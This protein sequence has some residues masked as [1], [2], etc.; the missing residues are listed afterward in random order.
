MEDKKSFSRV[1]FGLIIIFIA[2]LIF[3]TLVLRS[4]PF[5]VFDSS[6]II[7]SNF[8]GMYGIGLPIF[9]YLFK[10]REKLDVPRKEKISFK[11]GF[12]LF[13]I[14]FAVMYVVNLGCTVI[15]TLLGA[16]ITN[17]LGETIMGLNIVSAFLLIVIIGPILE[18]LLF[19]KTLYRFSDTL[20]EN[21]Y[22]IFS[23]IMFSLFHLNI[24]QSIYTFFLGIILAYLYVK[25]GKLIVPI[26]MHMVVN[27]VGSIIPLLLFGSET[28]VVFYSLIALI[29]VVAGLVFLIV[30]FSQVK[31][32]FKTDNHFSLS[33]SVR[34][35]GMIIF[36]ILS[37]GMILLGIF[38][39]FFI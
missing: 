13:T 27:F 3:Q 35:P 25:T 6:L 21:G 33:Q 9:L 26:V 38:G 5:A 14:G 2:G 19:R 23:S 8:I 22:I 32:I 39:A 7:V 18:E 28:A 20:G 1:G 30:N 24:T 10:D 17:Q 4:R 15:F 29:L 11:E 37:I 16:K 36:L 12:V 31:A 34:N